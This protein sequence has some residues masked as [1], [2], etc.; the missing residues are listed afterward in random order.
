MTAWTPGMVTQR[1]PIGRS[2]RS[3]IRIPPMLVRV[4]MS[5]VQ[6]DAT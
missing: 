1:G 6:F 4:L 3:S 2:F 5:M